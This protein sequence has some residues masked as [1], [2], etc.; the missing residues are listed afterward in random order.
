MKLIRL[1]DRDTKTLK[2]IQ[3]L[4]SP[5]S[6]IQPPDYKNRVVVKP[7]GHEFLVFQNEHVAVWCLRLEKGQ[8]TSMHCHPKKK[9]S[10][11]VLSGQAL[12]NTFFNRNYLNGVDGIVIE[13]GVF[14][15]TQALSQNGCDIIEIET[16]PDKLDLVRLDD[17]YGRSGKGYEGMSEMKSGNL[18]R[19]NH[20][21]FDEINQNEVFSHF[22]NT[23]EIS[24]INIPEER[25]AKEVLILSKGNLFCACKGGFIGLDGTEIAGIGE[26]VEGAF[27]TTFEDIKIQTGTV[28]LTFKGN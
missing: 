11:I 28:L 7:W 4:G 22:N 27:L 15:S 12:C 2:K 6:F 23:C 3:K 8:A 1:S 26:V 19:Y 5:R 20:F 18:E 14:H 25:L 10:L 21:F 13:A 24:L 16:P 9:T 17:Q